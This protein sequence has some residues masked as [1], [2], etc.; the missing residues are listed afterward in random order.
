MFPL[1]YSVISKHGISEAMAAIFEDDRSMAAE[2]LATAGWAPAEDHDWDSEDA[3]RRKDP[4]VDDRVR[5]LARKYHLGLVTNPEASISMADRT[6]PWMARCTN[7]KSQSTVILSHKPN[8]LT[9]V[10]DSL[11][12][13]PHGSSADMCNA[14]TNSNPTMPSPLRDEKKKVQEKQTTVDL[15]ADEAKPCRWKRK[16][17]GSKRFFPDNHL[18]FNAPIHIP[19]AMN[20]YLT[21][22]ITH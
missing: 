20:S 19:I 14:Q 8:L 3:E 17:G 22:I 21:L 9:R 15:T 18:P 2:L 5:T 6:N 16:K 10:R 4:V 12:P 1:K 13:Q 7:L 11:A